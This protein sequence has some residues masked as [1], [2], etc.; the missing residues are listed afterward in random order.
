MTNPVIESLMAHRSIRKYQAKAIEPQVVEAI[1]QAGMRAASASNLQRYSIVV[2]DDVAQKAALRLEHAPLVIITLVDEYRLQRW[3]RLYTSAPIENGRANNLFIGYW[4][5]ILAL[6][7]MVIAAE[8]LGLGACFI[9]RIVAEDIGQILGA[10]ERVFPAGMVC[11]GYPAESPALRPRLPEQA[12]VHHNRYRIPADAELDEFCAWR[13]AAWD[14]LS[15]VEKAKLAAE[16]MHNAAEQ[17]AIR[18]YSKEAGNE[19]VQGI[20]RNL[21]KAGFT[22]G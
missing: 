11:L 7:N 20:L 5:A 19:R 13:A 15:D 12:V 17:I 22:L 10:P 3:M 8:S 9:G 6:Q 1:V 18:H 14:A 16:G 2:V 4:D 21:K